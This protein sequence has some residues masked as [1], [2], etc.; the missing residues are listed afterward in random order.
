VHN[1]GDTPEFVLLGGLVPELLAD[2]HAGVFSD[3]QLSA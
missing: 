2:L 1:Y 3:Q